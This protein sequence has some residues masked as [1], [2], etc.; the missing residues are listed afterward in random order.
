[1][2]ECIENVSAN[3]TSWVCNKQQKQQSFR[4]QLQIWQDF[5]AYQR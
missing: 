3:T 5:W 2:Q 1:M 4:A